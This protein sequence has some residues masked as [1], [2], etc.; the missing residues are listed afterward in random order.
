MAC[1]DDLRLENKAG[2]K[3]GGSL[4][5]EKK[6]NNEENGIAYAALAHT[7]GGLEESRP[8]PLSRIIIK[9]D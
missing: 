3:R 6:G 4:G 5:E 7:Q 8:T 9:S 2:F 1:V